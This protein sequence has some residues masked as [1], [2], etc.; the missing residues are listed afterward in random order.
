VVNK[1]GEVTIVEHSVYQ[2]GSKNGWVSVDMSL[3]SVI[4]MTDVFDPGVF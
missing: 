4:P 1:N 3:I 2:Q